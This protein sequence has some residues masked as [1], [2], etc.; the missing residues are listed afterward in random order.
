MWLI[1]NTITLFKANV[2]V[3]EDEYSGT[4]QKGSHQQHNVTQLWRHNLPDGILHK[5]L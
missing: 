2:P 3:T 5:N 1:A 4:Y